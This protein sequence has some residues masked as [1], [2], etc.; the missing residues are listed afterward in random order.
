MHHPPS[1]LSTS[2][3]C[4]GQ[5]LPLVHF[6]AERMSC[7]I[8]CWRHYKNQCSGDP[9]HVC[10]T[11]VPAYQQYALF[12][13]YVGWL[14]CPNLLRLS[15]H[16][17]E[18]KRLPSART[19][20][21]RGGARAG[22]SVRTK[23]STDIKAPPPSPPPPPPR[24]CTSIHADGKSCIKQVCL[25]DSCVLKSKCITRETAIYMASSQYRVGHL[26]VW[27]DGH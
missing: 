3:K 9:N 4:V 10:C 16:V 15:P 21:V 25:Y 5:G 2:A 17:D 1:Y 19:A 11:N 6:S 26:S 12:M 23:H 7:Y 22:G 18:C 14:Q 13:G 8:A 24:V 20:S 27:S